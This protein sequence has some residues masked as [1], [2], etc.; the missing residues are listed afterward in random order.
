[1]LTEEFMIFRKCF[2]KA[3]QGLDLSDSERVAYYEAVI[4]YGLQ[5]DPKEAIVPESIR[6]I[7]NMSIAI[8]DE[9]RAWGD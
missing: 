3:I 8:I 7:Y 9:D 1:M 2:Y 5:D 6:G 4:E